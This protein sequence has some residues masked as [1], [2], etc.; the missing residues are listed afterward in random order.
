[1]K[2]K[3]CSKQD[4]HLTGIEQ[5][6]F[7][8]NFRKD[9]EK[10]RNECKNCKSKQDKTYGI[11]NIEN[12]KKNK[13]EYHR[14]NK[15]ALNSVSRE[16]RKNNKEAV[17]KKDKEYRDNNKEN[18]KERDRFYYLN[19]KILIKSKIYNKK[20]IRLVTDLI[21]RLKE[22]VSGSIFS[23]L[24]RNSS[25]KNGISCLKNL[26]YTIQELK[27]YLED[28]F[29][30]WM[31][32][33]NRGNYNPQTWNDND[34]LTWTWQ[35]DHIIPQSKLLYASMEDENFNKCWALSNLRPYSAK[36]NLLDGNR[37]Y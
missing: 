23:A 28:L 8:F 36:Q 25:S 29:E 5:N 27:E 32:W 21:F 26:N 24:K 20:K 6:I 18:I 9:S 11:N 22:S 35:L 37:R 33:N 17:K 12:I 1:M 4:C 31:N 7:N 2:T 10:Y 15:I 3:I 19:N 30:P 16:Y 14:N 13:K 34:S